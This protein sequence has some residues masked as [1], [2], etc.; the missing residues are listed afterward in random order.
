MQN[1]THCFYK[2][3]PSH[4]KSGIQKENVSRRLWTFLLLFILGE[5]LIMLSHKKDGGILIP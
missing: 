4:A 5:Q 2:L 3:L 1:V